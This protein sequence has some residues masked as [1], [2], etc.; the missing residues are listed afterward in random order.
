MANYFPS[1]FEK[2]L[3]AQNT[4]FIVHSSWEIILGIYIYVYILVVLF[5]NAFLFIYKQDKK[6]KYASVQKTAHISLKYLAP[7]FSAKSAMHS[8]VTLIGQLLVQSP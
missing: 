7:N 5:L 2:N 6:Y 4:V 3:F 1:N 8:E